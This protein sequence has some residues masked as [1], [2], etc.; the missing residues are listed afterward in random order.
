M[1][2]LMTVQ[3]HLAHLVALMDPP[4]TQAW[5][6]YCW[7]RAQDIA[8]DPEMAALPSLLTAEMQ[9]RSKA[10]IPTQKSTGERNDL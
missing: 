5:R 2:S 1:H 8:M 3:E 9:K 6:A 4:F 7:H 10:S